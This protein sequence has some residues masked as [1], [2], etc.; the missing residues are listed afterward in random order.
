MLYKVNNSEQ[1]FYERGLYTPPLDISQELIIVFDPGKTNMAMIIGTI[2][3][4]IIMVLEFSGKHINNRAMDTTDY[5]LE[6]MQFIRD[7]LKHCKIFKFAQEKAILPNSYGKGG[8]H[9]KG[10]DHYHSQMVLTEI[11]ANL[12]MLSV[13]MTGDKPEQINNMEWKGKILP[14]GYRGRDEKGS[15]RFIS[16]VNP[17]LSMYSHDVT[18]CICMYLFMV[19]KISDKIVITCDRPEKARFPYAFSIVDERMIPKDVKYFRFNDTFSCD[20]NASYFVNHVNLVGACKL[21]LNLIS[22]ED[23]YRYAHGLFSD[24]VPYMLVRRQ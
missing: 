18:D 14:D 19:Q 7:L 12:I 5:C 9:K 23:L 20:D 11:R 13:E 17:M 4:E 16:E 15:K 1:M 10:M 21:P 22:L 3:G 24:S 8:N 2:T 6:F